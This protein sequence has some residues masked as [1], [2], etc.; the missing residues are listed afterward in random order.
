MGG[1][2]RQHS[3]SGA[4]AVCRRRSAGGWDHVRRPPSQKAFVKPFGIQDLCPSPP[5]HSPPPP[6]DGPWGCPRASRPLGGR[7]AHIIEGNGVRDANQSTP[8][9][10]E[11][12]TDNTTPRPIWCRIQRAGGDSLTLACLGL[13]WLTLFESGTERALGNVFV[14]PPPPVGRGGCRPT[15][16]GPEGPLTAP[17]GGGD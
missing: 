8:E 14:P 6:G 1:C 15:G 9:H 16:R 5:H 10:C 13:P 17:W 7:C 2:K 4:A 3:P 11:G 12:A